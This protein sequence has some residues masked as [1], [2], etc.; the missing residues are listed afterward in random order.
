MIAARPHYGGCPSLSDGKHVTCC[1][2]HGDLAPTAPHKTTCGEADAHASQDLD[3][4]C[5]EDR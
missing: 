1:A 3:R 5:L 2:I 4:Y